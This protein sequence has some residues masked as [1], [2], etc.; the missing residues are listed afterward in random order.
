MVPEKTDHFPV[1]V[2]LTVELDVIN[3]FDF[4]WSSEAE[5]FPSAIASELKAELETLS[6]HPRLW[7][8]L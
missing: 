6:A 4:S 5:N 3:P 1:T 8:A 7:R 2:D